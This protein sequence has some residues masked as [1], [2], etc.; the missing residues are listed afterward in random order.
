MDEIDTT[1]VHDDDTFLTWL[2]TANAALVA[3]TARHCDIEG[4]LNQA[5]GATP[6]GSLL[7]AWRDDV[8]SEPIGECQ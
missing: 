7:A 1:A 6:V 4:R 3:D 2:T 8:N 5:R